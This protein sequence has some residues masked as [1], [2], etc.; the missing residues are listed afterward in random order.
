MATASRKA[1][2]APAR[3]RRTYY[4]HTLDGKPATW[5]EEGRQI[6]FADVLP[7]WQDR[8]CRALLR[9]SLRQIHR[10]QER[11]RAFRTAMRWDD[12]GEYGYVLVDVP[13]AAKP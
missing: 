10:D 11:T 8:P 7:R 5:S 1:P 9:S 12:V 2:K 13:E 3:T 6:V 4:M